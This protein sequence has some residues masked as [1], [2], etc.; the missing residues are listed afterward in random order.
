MADLKI[1]RINSRKCNESD[2][3]SIEIVDNIKNSERDSTDSTDFFFLFRTT[4]FTITIDAFDS[5]DQ[6]RNFIWI[7]V[8]F[9]LLQA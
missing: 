3:L 7:F 6:N 1:K 8:Q 2:R 9:I 4:V 5:R